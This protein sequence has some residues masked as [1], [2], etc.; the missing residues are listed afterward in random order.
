MLTFSSS[1]F[2]A[3][4]SRV[5]TA[6]GLI[7]STRAASSL[8]SSSRTRS[9]ITSRSPALSSRSADSSSGERPSDEPGV[10]P[11]RHRRPL[12]APAP[13]LLRPEPVERSR[14]GDLAEPG[15]GAA[16]AR[17][18][19][20]PVL[21]RLLERVG[22]QV[23]G[24][25]AVA[26]QVDEIGVHVVEMLLC[27]RGKGLPTR[28]VACGEASSPAH[29]VYAAGRRSVTGANLARMVHA[30]VVGASPGG[31]VRPGRA[32][33]QS[34]ADR[35]RRR[36]CRPRAR[37]G[38]P[39]LARPLGQLLPRD[40]ELDRPAA[41]RRLRRARSGRVHAAGRDRRLPR[42]LR[43]RRARARRSRRRRRRRVAMV[44]CCGPPPATS[45]P[46]SLVVATGT[47]RRPHLPPAAETLPASLMRL[48]VDDYRSPEGLPGRRRARRRQRPVGLPAR[49]GAARGRPRG[50]AR[51]R[52]RTVVAAAAGGRDLVWWLIESG[53]L[54][55]GS[56]SLPGPE[57]RLFAN[58]LATGRGGGHDLHLRVLRDARRHPCGPLPRN[59]GRRRPA[60]RPIS[61]TAS[62]GATTRYRQ[63]AGLFA[64]A[65]A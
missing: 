29:R 37:P 58:V 34:R 26:G 60:S 50:R 21:E 5:E 28:P 40:A 57:A 8:S 31:L 41:G 38:R 45:P 47:Y 2:R 6:V 56:T 27:G 35:A 22:G 30:R 52:S 42:G 23:L 43:R 49:G 20:A 17:V 64:E 25:R 59:R 1:F 14:A 24:Q 4:D 12:L 33:G 3:L 54:D 18:E 19:P 44:S 61:L 51:L 32:R 13:A 11:V 7:P 9:A 55:A 39:D 48:T 15:A 36:A 16:A 62:R 53:F 10:E 63:F 65:R 46:T